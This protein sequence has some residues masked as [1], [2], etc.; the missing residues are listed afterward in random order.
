MDIITFKT[1]QIPTSLDSLEKLETDSTVWFDFTRPQARNWVQ[2]IRKALP[3]DVDERHIADSLNELHPSFFDGTDSY[4]MIIFQGLSNTAWKEITT[5][6]TVFFLFDRCI[7]TIHAAHNRA[8]NLFKERLLNNTTAF[9]YNQSTPEKLLHQILNLLINQFMEIRDPLTGQL[10]EWRTKLLKRGFND[11]NAL[12]NH[13]RQLRK[14]ETLCEQ[15]V[16][17][18]MGWR[19]ETR[20]KFDD[21]MEV[22]YNDLL[23]HIK[24]VLRHVQGLQNEIEFLIELHFLVS[25]QHTNDIMRLLTLASVVFMPLNLI[26][27]IFGMNFNYMPFIETP[28]GFFYVA[29][30]MTI[31]AIFLYLLFKL[32]KWL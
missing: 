11:W 17:A 19:E 7:V 32:K 25:S 23:E 22:R 20:F 2:E 8:I 3:C 5:Q 30:S 12:M 26:A 21:Y 1:N 10:D 27:S 16:D 13:K 28:L 24:R 29:S 6:P 9:N 31:L 18:L 4:D 15:Q 14:V